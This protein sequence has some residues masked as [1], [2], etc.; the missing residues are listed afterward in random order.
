M[1]ISYILHFFLNEHPKFLIILETLTTKMAQK[2]AKKVQKIA[3]PRGF[4]SRI[5]HSSA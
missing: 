3:E 1:E 2:H 5:L 4:Q